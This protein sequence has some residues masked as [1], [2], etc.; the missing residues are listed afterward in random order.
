MPS[1]CTQV[2]AWTFSPDSGVEYRLGERHIDAAEGVDNVGELI[3]VEGHGVLDGNPEVFLD[4]RHQLREALKQPG[5]D[6]VGTGTPCVGDEQVA[7]DREQCQLMVR[8]VSVEDHDHVAVHAVHALGAEPVG[9]VLHRQGAAGRGSHHQDVLAARLLSRSEGRVQSL[10]M[11]PVQ[12]VGQVIG[13]AG[14]TS[15]HHQHDSQADQH[16]PS[17]DAPPPAPHLPGSLSG[18]PALPGAAPVHRFPESRQT[19]L[20]RRRPASRAGGTAGI[21]GGLPRVLPGTLFPLDLIAEI[22]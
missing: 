12:I 5:I 8:R 19:R 7:R 3:E 10:Y 2:A 1:R 18:P 16:H 4:R 14:A 15:E 6:F 13:V 22:A 20:V 21:A 9:R 17:Q 11:H